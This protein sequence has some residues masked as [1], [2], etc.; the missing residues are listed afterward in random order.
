[1]SQFLPNY[2]KD[3]PCLRPYGGRSSTKQCMAPRQPCCT[4]IRSKVVLLATNSAMVFSNCASHGM[5]VMTTL[6]PLPFSYI[7][8]ATSAG[9]PMPPFWMRAESSLTRSAPLAYPAR[10]STLAPATP[11][12]NTRRVVFMAALPLLVTLPLLG[13][14]HDAV[15]LF[16][17]GLDRILGF[18]PAEQHV[19]D[20]V[21]DHLADL[22]LFGHADA[23]VERLKPITQ[24]LPGR[25]DFLELRILEHVNA[26]RPVGRLER[27]GQLG[28]PAHHELHGLEGGLLPL[29]RDPLV[30]PEVPA[31]ALVAPGPDRGLG[32]N[33][34]EKQGIAHLPGNL[35]L[36]RILHERDPGREHHRLGDQALLEG[37]EDIQN[38]PGQ[39][40]LG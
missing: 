14:L 5:G 18:L 26:A 25:V 1:M 4:G 12:R 38:S 2:C 36:R 23:A 3:G 21:A 22:R 29:I 9:G 15:H 13:F 24:R 20:P 37:C 31:V 39:D 16:P 32:R 30:D 35:G 8:R 19:G 40:A 10:P 7:F 11:F 27:C 6:T 28:L 34:G 33:L 17:C